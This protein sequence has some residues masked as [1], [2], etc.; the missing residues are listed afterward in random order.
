MKNRRIPT[1]VLAGAVGLGGLTSAA[2]LVPAAASAA[3]GDDTV[4]G[5]VP[6]RLSSLS[7]A[8]S[9]LVSDGTL[10]QEQADAV[11]TTLDEALPQRGGPGGHGPGGHG[12]GG[13]RHLETAAEVLGTS[14]DEL[15]D[16]LQDGSSLA[17]VAAAEGVETSALV[18][19]LVAAAQERLADHVEA[20]DVTQEQADERLAEV[21]ARVTEMVER[22]GLPLGPGRMGPA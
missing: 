5:A 1:L 20:G 13:G 7:E 19:A 11:A 10:S 6:D 14:V 2:V 21:T 8:L 17:D 16:A 18:D 12:M 22:D 9:G 15:R 3:T 4:A